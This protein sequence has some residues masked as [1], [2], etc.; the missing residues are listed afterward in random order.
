MAQS[1]PKPDPGRC[2]LHNHAIESPGL[3][4]WSDCTMNSSSPYTLQTNT[5]CKHSIQSAWG[6]N[7]RIISAH[8]LPQRP[9]HGAGRSV[10]RNPTKFH[11]NFEM[12]I[13]SPSL[14]QTLTV[15]NHSLHLWTSLFPKSWPMDL[16]D[17]KKHAQ[18]FT[19]S[20]SE[21]ESVQEVAPQS[22]AHGMVCVPN[23]SPNLCMNTKRMPG[24]RHASGSSPAVLHDCRCLY[25]VVSSCTLARLCTA[26]S[27]KR[28]RTKAAGEAADGSA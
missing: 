1:T 3:C 2:G 16:C 26:P 6:W 7:L 15:N 25:M 27:P 5:H 17:K 13:P 4:A 14:L 8:N 23:P 21:A 24:Y 28:R 12:N 22:G 19:S 10:S 9:R 18:F 20:G 11:C